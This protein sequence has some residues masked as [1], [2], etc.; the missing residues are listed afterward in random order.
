MF[1]GAVEVVLGDLAHAIDAG[2][3]GAIGGRRIIESGIRAA[4]CKEAMGAAS[5]AVSSDD[6]AN[7]VDAQCNGGAG[8]GGIVERGVD[9]DWHDTGS[10]VIVALWRRAPGIGQAPPRRRPPSCGLRYC[11]QRLL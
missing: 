3:I 11:Q 4:A 10:S 8:G 9:I 2:C 6:L 5:V 7:P 1:A